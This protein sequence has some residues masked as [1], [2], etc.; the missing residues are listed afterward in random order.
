MKGGALVAST[1]SLRSSLF[2]TVLLLIKP[3][4]SATSIRAN[5]LYGAAR[6]SSGRY[7]LQS[8]IIDLDLK[9]D[10]IAAELAVVSS[11]RDSCRQGY[12]ELTAAFSAFVNG[13]TE[14]MFICTGCTV[15]H[16][17]RRSDVL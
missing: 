15:T 5:V 3:D 1:V 17:E 16:V 14:D 6:D 7:A 13:V 8:N 11:K 9:R 4:T 10:D 12:Y 2:S